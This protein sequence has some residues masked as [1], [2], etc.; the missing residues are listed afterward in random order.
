MAIV[1]RGP[2]RDQVSCP[3]LLQS[4]ATGDILHKEIGFVSDL[5][6]RLMESAGQVI[7]EVDK[8]G[9]IQSAIGGLRHRLAEADRKRKVNQ[10]RQRIRDL[11]TQEVQAINALSSQ[12]LALHEAGTLQQPELVSLCKGVDDVRLQIK[13]A[14]AELEGLLPAQPQPAAQGRC[15]NCGA[16]VTADAAF[17]QACGARLGEAPAATPVL[18]CVHCGGQLREISQFCPKCGQAVTRP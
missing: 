16:V 4:A 17:C 6:D 7:S 9:Q 15:H 14:E 10:I 3:H 8:G 5:F 11:K 18:Y 1:R 2:A 12:V 13:E